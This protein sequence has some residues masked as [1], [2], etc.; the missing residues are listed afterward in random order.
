MKRDD[1]RCLTEARVIADDLRELLGH[2]LPGD[3]ANQT[4]AQDMAIRALAHTSASAVLD[5][6]CGAGDSVDLFR[7]LEP[8]ASWIGL[9]VDGSAEVL[10]RTRTDAEFT[11]FDGEHFPFADGS[12]DFVYCTQ[13]LEHVPRPEPLVAEIARV[14]RPG[15]RLVGSTSQ[16]EPFHSRSTFGYSPY[17]LSLLFERSG[18]EVSEL[19]PGIDSLTLILRRGLGGPHCFDRWWARES[20]LNRA[21]GLFARVSRLDPAATNAVKLLFCGQLAFSARRSHQARPSVTTPT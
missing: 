17:G 14:L 15:G 1:P 12:F 8:T 16:L 5:V 2:R 4:L 10:A 13:V 19:R 20:P 7:R 3:H 11:S 18:L 9:D 21:I 6:G